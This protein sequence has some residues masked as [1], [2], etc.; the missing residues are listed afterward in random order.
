MSLSSG[1]DGWGGC[2]DT[3]Q[4]SCRTHTSQTLHNDGPLNGHLIRNGATQ[5]FTESQR[6]FVWLTLLCVSA[7]VALVVCFALF[8]LTVTMSY[9]NYVLVC[10]LGSDSLVCGRGCVFTGVTKLPS[11]SWHKSWT[12][13]ERNVQLHIQFE[14]LWS[15]AFEWTGRKAVEVGSWNIYWSCLSSVIM[16]ADWILTRLRRWIIVCISIFYTATLCSYSSA[17]AQI[18]T[19]KGA[20]VCWTQAFDLG[21]WGHGWKKKRKNTAVE[22]MKRTNVL[23]ILAPGNMTHNGCL[24]VMALNV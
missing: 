15:T 4:S 3:G 10:L 2:L 9:S 18:M 16:N 13:I 24:S 21:G 12:L 6:V 11:I 5:C 1:T 14:S 17:W 7:C 8:F 19:G 23:L 22:K 20:L